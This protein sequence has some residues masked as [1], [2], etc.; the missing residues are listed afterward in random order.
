MPASTQQITTSRP[1]TQ[2]PTSNHRVRISFWIALGQTS[3]I[4]RF[5][6]DPDPGADAVAASF[7]RGQKD[8]KFPHCKSERPGGANPESG[9]A[10]FR[11]QI[12]PQLVV[13]N[14]WSSRRTAANADGTDGVGGMIEAVFCF[15][16]PFSSVIRVICVIRGYQENILLIRGGF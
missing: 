10:A 14:Q 13:N 15:L 4:S 11:E 16:A 8:T 3:D 7:P 2:M 5:V 12:S 9:C 6:G 1:A